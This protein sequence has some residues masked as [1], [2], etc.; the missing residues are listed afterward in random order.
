MISPDPKPWGECVLCGGA[1][2]IGD[3]HY[4]IGDG[5]VVAKEI[6]TIEHPDG[7]KDVNIQ[8]N[9]LDV[10]VHDEAT[11]HAKDVIENQ[12]LPELAKSPVVVIVLHKP[13]NASAYKVVRLCDVRKY[14]ET[15]VDVFMKTQAT[16]ENMG[17]VEDF[18]I[19]EY[20]I[21]HNEIKISS[22]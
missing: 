4:C 15:A 11:R 2:K 13:T 21:K 19:I 5:K 9:R 14:A 10:D 18:V 12:I 3:G 17:R 22:L 8:V 16:A 20:H 7:R 6:H 1:Y